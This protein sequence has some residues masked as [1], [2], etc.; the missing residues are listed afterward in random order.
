MPR[1]TRTFIAVAIPAPLGEKLS[2]LQSELAPVL[3][4]VRWTTTLPFHV[5]LAFLGD[6]DDRDLNGICKAVRDAVSIV[7]RFEARVEEIGAFPGPAR[8]RVIWAGLTA[9]DATPL[10]ELHKAV[11]KAATTA[12]YRPEDQ[13]FHPHV[14]LGRLKSDRLGPPPPD[15]TETIEHHRTWSAGS[16]TVNEVISFGSTL[17]PEGPV[18]ATLAKAPLAA[19]KT[20]ASP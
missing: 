11:V 1:T 17:T 10:H 9:P 13:R 8:P 15:L 12:G 20:D 3:P 16:F 6:V 19:R 5:T 14:T 18:Y 4:G 2:R 7:P